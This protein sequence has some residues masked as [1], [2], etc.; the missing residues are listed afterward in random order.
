MSSSGTSDVPD[1]AST[2]LSSVP[3]VAPPTDYRRQLSLGLIAITL[4][5]GGL[6]LWSILVP[7]SSAFVGTGFVVAGKRTAVQHLNGGHVR[8]LHVHEGDKVQA[9]QPLL[10]VS[11]VEAAA[12]L[13][14]LQNR[15]RANQAREARLLAERDGLSSVV[16][17]QAMRDDENVRELLDAEASFFEVRRAKLLGD[18]GIV[19]AR[20]KQTEAEIISLIKQREAIERQLHLT[21]EELVDVRTLVLRGYATATRARD[22]ERAREELRA[23]LGRLIGAK[24]RAEAAIAVLGLEIEQIRRRFRN[25]VETELDEVRQER[26][27]LFGRLRAALNEE[28][29]LTIRA[30]L[31]G[32]VIDLKVPGPGVIVR[33]GEKILEIVPSNAQ[34]EVE[35]AVPPQEAHGLER[36]MAAEVR[37]QTMDGGDSATFPAIVNVVSADRM[38]NE[39]TGAD[40]FL[41]RIGFEYQHGDRSRRI[42]FKPGLPVEVAI[43]KGVR[44]P[45]S[46]L[47]RPLSDVL[48]RAFR[49]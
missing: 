9:D 15:Q 21:E 35:V 23:E 14:I 45:L 24:E 39:R 41:A 38:T 44:S 48:A 7:L 1:A 43:Q 19:A 42:E 16:F 46:Y 36:G 26:F 13:E 29:L 4:T 6:L 32:T 11:D 12:E 17:A 31:S 34:L 22:L 27:E 37:I 5:F 3:H 18:M 25:E 30:P 47:T 40:Y 2:S 28:Q 20:R 49:E 33:P 10:T 8:Q